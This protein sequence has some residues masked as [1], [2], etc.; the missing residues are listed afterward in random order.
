MK[1]NLQ[2]RKKRGRKP[3]QWMFDLTE[4][5]VK[6]GSITLAELSSQ[7][8]ASPTAI[9]SFCRRQK[10]KCFYLVRERGIAEKSFLVVDLKKVV[11]DY[12][13]NAHIT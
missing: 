11:S 4:L 8:G 10:I 3:A 5:S 7:L 2:E 6:S 9:R 12:V 1:I 13:Y